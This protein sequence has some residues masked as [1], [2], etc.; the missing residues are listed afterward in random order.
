MTPAFLDWA[1]GRMGSLSIV[2]G[3]TDVGETLGQVSIARL[4]RQIG[5]LDEL[6]L[7]GRPVAPR[8]VMFLDGYPDGLLI[9][10]AGV[11]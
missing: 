9:E 11:K 8:E 6:D 5:A 4:A 1:Y 3:R 10:S 2:H 7:L